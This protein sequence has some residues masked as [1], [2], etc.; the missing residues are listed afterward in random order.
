MQE[1]DSNPKFS[2]C[3]TEIVDA[4]IERVWGLLTNPAGW[5]DFY[6]VN[7]LKVVPLGPAHAGQLVIG[8]WSD[9]ITPKIRFEF[10]AV[11]HSAHRLRFDVFMPFGITV[12][13][14]MVCTPIGHDKCRVTYGCHFEFTAGWRGRFVRWIL[15]KELVAGPA[16]SLARLKRAAEKTPT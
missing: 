5:G 11:D 9:P 8:G 16:D 10:L 14:D 15:K 13:E 12:R 2:S 7:I 6:D 4:P 3:P 1:S